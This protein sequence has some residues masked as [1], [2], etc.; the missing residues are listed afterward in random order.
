MGCCE[1]KYSVESKELRVGPN[2]ENGQLMHKKPELPNDFWGRVC[3][4]Q[5]RERVLGCLI[6]SW[7]FFDWLVM[8]FQFSSVQL[9]RSVQLFATP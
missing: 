6:S 9:L 4:G 8:M 1:G 3:R 5:V 2:E 7:T